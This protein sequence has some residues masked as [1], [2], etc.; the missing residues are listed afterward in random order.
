MTTILYPER[1]YADDRY[2]CEIFPG[3]AT[4]VMRDTALLSE[5]SDEDCAAAEGLMLFRQWARAEDIA[6]F[7]R[8]R[9]IVRMGVGYDRI[10]R[11][12]AARRGIIVCNVPDYGTTEVADHAI[13]LTLA[14]RRGL[15]M[16]H[17]A[18]RAHPPAAW[19]A[20]TSPLLRRLSAQKFG[21][22]GL[23]RI[24]T[25]V[26]LRAKALGFDVVFYD[27]FR[28]N[29]TELSLGIRR[30]TSLEALLKQADVLSLHTPHTPQTAGMIGAAQLALLPAN[31]VVV[32]TARGTAIDI[33]ALEAALRSGHLAGAG[34]DVLPVEPPVEPIPGL[35][36]AYRER[37]EWTIG[38]L[39]I[40]P[41]SA[42]LTPESHHDIRIK[43]AETM[44]A[45]LFSNQP[46]NVIAPDDH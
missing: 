23:G 18:Q 24:G 40:T 14:L 33:D 45:A 11:A 42:F 38:R 12:A 30:A 35:L 31:A 36:K 39:I 17:D 27:P 32:S 13:A 22:V 15:L 46:Q 2:E 41:H 16:H 8:L 29:G 3:D 20:N 25:A 44:R 6:R 34:L 26:A 9:A 21:I 4:I 37:A 1:M 19:V 28:S 7:P 5:L 10:D 43:S